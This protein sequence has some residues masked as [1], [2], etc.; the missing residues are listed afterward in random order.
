MDM[1]MDMDMA[2]VIRIMDMDMDTVGAIRITDTVIQVTDV[3][4]QAMDMVPLMHTTTI[5]AEEALH[6][7]VATT[8]TPIIITLETA[9]TIEAV[10]TI[11]AA[12][13]AETTLTAGTG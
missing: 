1:D 3:D 10:L 12:H 4:I 11:E 7:E 8:T 13:I 9:L 2:G 5:T 6:M